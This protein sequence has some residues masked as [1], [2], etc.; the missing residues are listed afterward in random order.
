MQNIELNEVLKTAIL[1]ALS[2]AKVV[3]PYFG[4]PETLN[5][6]E[7]SDRSQV[8]ETDLASG[9]TIH[10]VIQSR[11]P[12]HGIMSEE[13][14]EINPSQY[15]YLWV[16]D[17]IDGTTNF[18]SG[19]PYF[20]ISIGF[21]IDEEPV[22]G[23]I[24]LPRII[25]YR[26]DGIPRLAWDIVSGGKKIGAY[27]NRR[28]LSLGRRKSTVSEALVH[29]DF[30]YKSEVGPSEWARNVFVDLQK[31]ARVVH[32]SGSAVRELVDVMLG[33]YDGCVH[34][35]N[36]PWDVAAT[37]PMLRELGFDV[38]NWRGELWRLMN[39]SAIVDYGDI[40]SNLLKIVGRNAPESLRQN[41][42]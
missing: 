16:T 5:I 9:R 10:E 37:C 3:T 28:R 8:T 19:N 34:V 35:L 1:A 13:G 41:Y 27:Y 23:A 38:T 14:E 26:K 6:K 33:Q 22:L 39:K 21:A 4:N 25:G 29:T 24:A 11:F 42:V 2:A 40:H 18:A 7:K 36:K 32:V 15:R 17:E 20:A 31:E 12:D 30:P